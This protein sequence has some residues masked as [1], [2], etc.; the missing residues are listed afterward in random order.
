MI[1]Q[2]VVILLSSLS[3]TLHAITGVGACCRFT[4]TCTQYAVGAV[5][6]LGIFRG[7]AFVIRRLLKCRPLGP[8]GYD[9]IPKGDA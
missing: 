8:F 1:V 2:G 3:R 9:P 4:P 7:G 6:G 5:E